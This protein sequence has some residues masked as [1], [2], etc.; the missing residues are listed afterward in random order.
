M[1]ALVLVRHK[2]NIVRLLNGTEPRLGERHLPERSAEGAS[3]GEEAQQ[4]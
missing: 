2:N 4:T 3:P 1:A